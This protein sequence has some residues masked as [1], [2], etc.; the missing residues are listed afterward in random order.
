VVRIRAIGRTEIHLGNSRIGPESAVLFAIVLYLACH[1]GERVSRARLLELLWPR[2]PEAS[3]RHALRQLLYRL[4]RSGLNVTLEGADLFLDR[5]H[6]DSDLADVLSSGWPATAGPEDVVRAGTLLP[7]YAPALSEL[8]LRWLDELRARVEPQYRRAVLRHLAQ[9]KHEGRWADVA[10]WARRCL[11]TDPL[12]E[13]ATLASAEAL[14]MCGS[15][16]RALD[17]IEQYRGEL[18][19][20]EKTIGL[21]ARVLTRR[22]SEQQSR[23]PLGTAPISCVGRAARSGDGAPQRSPRPGRHQ[24]SRRRADGGTGGHRQEHGDPAAGGRCAPER[25]AIHLYAIAGE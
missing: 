9:S 24:A 4:R 11:A 1:A 23:R 17:V 16:T 7:G 22:I 8:Y 2:V 20:R 21:P 13:E 3:R 15:K 18:G 19:D 5:A 14:V 10:E 25:L 12:N 6:V